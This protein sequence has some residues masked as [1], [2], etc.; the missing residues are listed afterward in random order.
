MYVHKPFHSING[1]WVVNITE[2]RNP[3]LP[4]LERL[5]FNSREA[6]W[7]GYRHIQRERGVGL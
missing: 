3:L 5:E 7:K 4:V 1:K 2:T 6:A